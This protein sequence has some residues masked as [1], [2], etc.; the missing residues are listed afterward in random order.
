MKQYVGLMES[1]QTN[2]GGRVFGELAL[3]VADELDLAAM[4]HVPILKPS[5]GYDKQMRALLQ[6]SRV[7]TS[8]SEL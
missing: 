8:S 5:K 7:W 6:G 4:S 2:A 1:G 3:E